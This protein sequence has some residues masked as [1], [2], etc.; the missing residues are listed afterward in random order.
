MSGVEGAATRPIDAV[1]ARVRAVYGRW[2]RGTTVQQ[3]R[4]DWDRLFAAPPDLD[5]RVEPVDANGVPAEWISPPGEATDGAVLYFHGGGF[6][7]GSLASH[8]ELM[9]CIAAASGCR[10]LGVGYRL[11]PEHR[12]PAALDDA[13]TAYAWLLSR[14]RKGAASIALAGDSAGAGLAL[15]L[16][17]SLRDAGAPLPAAALLMSPWT[18]L[19]ASGASYETRADADPIHQRAMILAMARGY[20]GKDGDARVP[21]ASPLF[22]QLSGLP[23]MLVQVGDRETVRS[24]ATDFVDKACAAGVDARIEVWDDMIHVFQQF[25]H[26]LAEARQALQSAGA[27]LRA[28]LSS[29]LRVR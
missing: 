12:Y 2:G 16:M 5:A 6:Q 19:S 13:R 23:P 26:D 10:V 15:S 11:A 18:D 9:A 3:M 22:G 1:I 7:V 27:F 28:R 29:P 8:R 21:Y 14:Q 25:P 24:D 4:A 17:L 20:L